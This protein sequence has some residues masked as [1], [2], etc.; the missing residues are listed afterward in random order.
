MSPSSSPSKTMLR[1]VPRSKIGIWGPKACFLTAPGSNPGR[2]DL[3]SSDLPLDQVA[4]ANEGEAT[5]SRC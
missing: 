3:K 5:G 1:G 2:A 4:D